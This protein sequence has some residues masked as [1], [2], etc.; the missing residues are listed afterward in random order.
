VCHWGG[1]FQ[2]KHCGVSL[3]WPLPME[4]LRCVIGV[5]PS[6]GNTAVCHWGG[7]FQWKHCGVS[8]GSKN[9]GVAGKM[10]PLCYAV[11]LPIVSLDKATSKQS[12]LVATR[13]VSA[14]RYSIAMSWCTYPSHVHQRERGRCRRQ[15]HLSRA[16]RPP[17]FADA[18]RCRWL[19]C[20][21]VMSTLCLPPCCRILRLR[22]FAFGLG[23][24]SLGA[25]SASGDGEDPS[26]LELTSGNSEHRNEGTP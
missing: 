18:R 14:Q 10:V 19:P 25:P 11:I 2:R 21:H 8:L 6:N 15:G 12:P 24:P 20:S 3:G 7:P 9:V 16:D 5:A 1:P 26:P 13:L 4:T 23:F 22:Q 17:S